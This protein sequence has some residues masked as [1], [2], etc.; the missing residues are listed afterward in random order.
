MRA[1][2]KIVHAIHYFA[3]GLCLLLSDSLTATAQVD[4]TYTEAPVQIRLKPDKTTI[5]LGEPKRV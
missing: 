2:T 5:M 4:E 1:T 3:V